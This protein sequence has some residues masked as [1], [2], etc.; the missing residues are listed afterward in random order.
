MAQ[1]DLVSLVL[2]SK[3][4]FQHGESL[5]S[6][7]HAFTNLSADVAIDVLELDAR[8]RW[9]SDAVIGQ[10][11]VAAEVAKSIEQKRAELE[12]TIDDYDRQRQRHTSALD[13][14][15][16][17]LGTQSV[18][19][20]FY[21]DPDAEDDGVFASPDEVED[22]RGSPDTIRGV[23]R[24]SN[25]GSASAV[26]KSDK[27][28]WKTL[29]DFVDE[30]AIEDILEFMEN[31]RTVLDKTLDGIAS[32]PTTIEAAIE[33]IENALPSSP[34]ANTP[35]VPSPYAQSQPLSMNDPT[36]SNRS[37]PDGSAQPTPEEQTPMNR[38]S[39]L[40]PLE[41]TISLRPSLARVSDV[42]RVQERVS[43]GMAHHL[44]SLAAHYDAM[45]AALKDGESGAAF[46]DEDLAEM[47]R[48]AGELGSIIAELEQSCSSIET[49]YEQMQ[50]FLSTAQGQLDTHRATLD[51]LDELEEMMDDMVQRVE[52]VEIQIS[53]QITNLHGHL[54][55]LEN[56]QLRYISYQFSYN[57]LL[58]EL[59]RRRQYRDA[60]ERIVN[61]MLAQLHV[62][63]EEEHAVREAF[64]HEHG[65][66]L[67]EDLCLCISNPP[68]RWD[69]VPASWETGS[70]TIGPGRTPSA[71]RTSVVLKDKEVLPEVD[72]ALLKEARDNIV[73]ANNK[74]LGEGMGHESL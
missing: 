21:T 16:E 69:I 55:D 61:D 15:L 62:M 34:T 36:T 20:D 71:S 26:L 28:K 37:P 31:E 63:A 58:L 23:R 57:K 67:P 25:A 14:I 3:K 1:A 38:S 56:L 74:G 7:A 73:A 41:A 66:N 47:H 65:P 30:R 11:K 24:P 35:A 17:T 51:D 46:D 48:D 32:L 10:L 42:L 27:R 39:Q 44:E 40:P 52:R 9:I 49:G 18:P 19:P 50:R 45:A 29:R 4:A 68:T 12:S 60:A 13:A 70:S 54:V 53:T 33:A 72:D 43:T 22:A 59:G 64:N 8:V 2:Q 5:C 6:R